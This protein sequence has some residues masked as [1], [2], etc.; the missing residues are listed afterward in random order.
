[1]PIQIFFYDWYR[2]KTNTDTFINIDAHTD[3]VL[4]DTDMIETDID[5][6]VSA[7]NIGQPIYRSVY[8]YTSYILATL[9]LAI[10]NV[11]KYYTWWMDSRMAAGKIWIKTNSTHPLGFR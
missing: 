11:F 7:K 8:L 9:S 6:S 3:I 2:L 10:V 5:V 4:A 1:M